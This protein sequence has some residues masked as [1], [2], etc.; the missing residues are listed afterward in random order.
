MRFKDG[1]HG[2]DEWAGGVVLAAVAT[3]VAHVADLSF[4]EVGEFVLLLLRVEAEGVD[5][6]EDFAEV[7]AGLQLVLD[8]AEDF[9]NFVFEGL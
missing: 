6:F 2:E 4:V 5:F 8:L 3:S 7:V 1:E 9:A